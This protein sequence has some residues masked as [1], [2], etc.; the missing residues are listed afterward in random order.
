MP[1]RPFIMGEH[2]PE[3][4]TVIL[5]VEVS[6]EHHA[7]LRT[8]RSEWANI[9][10]QARARLG[11]LSRQR[12]LAL[13]AAVLLALFVFAF[14]FDQRLGIWALLPSAVFVGV[15]FERWQRHVMESAR[16]EAMQM[17]RQAH[18]QALVQVMRRE[19]PF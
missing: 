3:D 9:E 18:C 19:E 7:R 10:N 13:V 14:R 8:S 2:S 17:A 11:P 4:R 5:T 12:L 15:C 1:C 6:R 16:A